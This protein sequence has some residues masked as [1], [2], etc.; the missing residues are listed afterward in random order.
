MKTHKNPSLSLLSVI[1]TAI[2]LITRPVY[3]LIAITLIGLFPAKKLKPTASFQ[4]SN[5]EHTSRSYYVSTE[6]IMLRTRRVLGLNLNPR[7]NIWID[8][9]E[10]LEE[11]HQLRFLEEFDFVLS[12]D[13]PIQY[14]DPMQ[15]WD[16]EEA[17]KS[18]YEKHEKTQQQL[19][20]E[21][22]FLSAYISTLRYCSL[23]YWPYEW[24]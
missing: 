22:E 21:I 8:K 4:P 15:E 6:D 13:N 12:T 20:P 14:L 19:V 10:Y 9:I 11:L 1:V 16:L 23:E 24:I 2:S 5:V 3:L 17:I 18:I 7:A